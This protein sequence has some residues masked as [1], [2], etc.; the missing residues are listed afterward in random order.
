MIISEI[1]CKNKVGLSDMTFN[2]V[3]ITYKLCD[4]RQLT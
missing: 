2:F 4:L 3:S 1:E